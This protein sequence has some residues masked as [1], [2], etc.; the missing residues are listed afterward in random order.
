MHTHLNAKHTHIIKEFFPNF[1]HEKKDGKSVQAPTFSDDMKAKRV[2]LQTSTDDAEEG[3]GAISIKSIVPQK[4]PTGISAKTAVLSTTEDPDSQ[5]DMEFMDQDEGHE[6]IEVL[7]VNTDYI[8]LNNDQ[9]DMD[10][11][12]EQ[13]HI[14]HTTESSPSND[15]R[16]SV[17]VLDPEDL[18]QFE[19]TDDEQLGQSS[20]VVRKSETDIPQMDVSVKL[21]PVNNVRSA[22]ARASLNIE[23]QLTQ[24]IITDLVSPDILD[25]KGFQQFVSKFY[26]DDELPSSAVVN[27]LF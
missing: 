17:S 2:K 7:D 3:Y 4:H 22:S 25:G 21:Q 6:L 10:T 14:E 23:E 16:F 15:R 5:N 24:F 9:F 19:R 13:A 1:K 27:I 12:L 8:E 18:S 20:L 26:G 11:E